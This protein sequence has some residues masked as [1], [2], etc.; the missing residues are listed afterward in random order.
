MS[1]LPAGREGLPLTA[2]QSGM[3]MGQALAPG[4]VRHH[5]GI[6][7]EVAGALHPETFETA[8]R[9]VIAE[10]EALRARFTVGPDGEPR[11]HTGP[12]PQWG[13][14]YVDL[15]GERHPRRA[16][17]AWMRA[18]LARPFDLERGPLFR[19]AL[20][21]LSASSTCWYLGAHHLVL[22][23]FSSS[24]FSRRLSGVYAAM[25]NGQPPTAGE[26]GPLSALLDDEAAYRAS[27]AHLADRGFWLGRTAGRP[28]P[29][30]LTWTSAPRGDEADAR[31]AAADGL[32]LR[33]SAVL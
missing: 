27:P 11:Q 15:S 1:V 21:R 12:L 9:H 10:A 13:V 7:V 19:G 22:D 20:L 8:F 2:A 5:V 29:G 14:P 33:R 24:L 30:D 26:F 31:H 23:G 3:W 4:S 25:E 28:G 18:D 16:A 6:S 17:T 32:A